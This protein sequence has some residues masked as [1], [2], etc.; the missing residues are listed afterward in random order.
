MLTRTE[1]IA[2]KH[3]LQS[4]LDH[5]DQQRAGLSAEAFGPSSEEG[6]G[7][8]LPRRPDEQGGVCLEEEVTLGL[9][10]NEEHLVGQITAALGRLIAGTYGCCAN[11]GQPIPVR[12][13][14]AVPY[15]SHCIGCARLAPPPAGG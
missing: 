5:L 13:L 15:A 8:D 3:R 6:G 11:C 12:R 10:Q 4:Q 7:W 2:T 14:R 9:L 1:L